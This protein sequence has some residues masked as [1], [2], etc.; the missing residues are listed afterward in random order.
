MSAFGRKIGDRS[1]A[2][3]QEP[4][5]SATALPCGSDPR[6]ARRLDWGARHDQV[7]NQEPYRR[8]ARASYRAALHEKMSPSA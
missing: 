3:G 2:S 4:L 8:R 1:G 5:K 6:T 7:V